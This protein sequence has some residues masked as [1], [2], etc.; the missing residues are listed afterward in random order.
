MGTRIQVAFDAAEPHAL[1][2]FWAAA[3]RYEVEDHSGLVDHLLGA[4]YIQGSDIIDLDG[5][6]AFRDATA[7]SDPEGAGPRLYFQRVPEAKQAKNRVHLDLE[8]GQERREAEVERL[9]DLGATVLWITA[10]RGPVTTTLGDPEGNEL[11]V[12]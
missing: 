3:M 2:R 4:G 12:C 5:R 8:V 7:C 11:C 10:D 9:V 6:K 1:A